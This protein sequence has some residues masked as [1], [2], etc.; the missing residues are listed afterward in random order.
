MQFDGMTKRSPA[1]HLGPHV[2][3]CRR[4]TVAQDKLRSYWTKPIRRWFND[5]GLKL[6]DLPYHLPEFNANE[7]V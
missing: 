1:F 3:K 6:L 5:H 4:Y 2:H 7:N